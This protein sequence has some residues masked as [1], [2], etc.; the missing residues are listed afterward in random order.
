MQIGTW[1]LKKFKYYISVSKILK[2]VSSV[3]NWLYILFCRLN[4]SMKELNNNEK[5][6]DF[7]RLLLT[8]NPINRPSAK[9]VISYIT[10]WDNITIQ[11]P[12]YFNNIGWNNRNKKATNEEF[13]N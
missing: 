12:V 7:C 8:P 1:D 10:N 11:L 3:K 13:K 5:L 4:E 9:D 6:V 2:K